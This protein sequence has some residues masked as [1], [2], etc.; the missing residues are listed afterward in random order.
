MSFT[1]DI[2]PDSLDTYNPDIDW[3]GGGT[4]S[5]GSGASFST[6]EFS[7][8]DEFLLV[9]EGPDGPRTV[10]FTLPEE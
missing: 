5:T 2:K 1:A 10:T 7:E 3:S 8:T 6:R 9:V 4:P